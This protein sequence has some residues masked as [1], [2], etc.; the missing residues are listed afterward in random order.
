MAQTVEFRE[1]VYG[2]VT[3]Q[4][5]GGNPQIINYLVQYAGEHTTIGGGVAE[6][7]TLAGVLSTDVVVAFV[8]FTGTVPA[9]LL[10][11]TPTTNTITFTFSG[12]PNAGTAHRVMYAVLRAV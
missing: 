5:S 1:T 2:Q 9:F 11:T 6:V 3:Q 4:A 7:K 8:S 12:N 10:K